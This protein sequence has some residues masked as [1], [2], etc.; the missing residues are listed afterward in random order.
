[1]MNSVTKLP[2][3]KICSGALNIRLPRSLV[4]ADEGLERLCT[5]LSVYFKKGGMQAQLSV[6]DV[7]ELLAAQEKPEDYKDLMVRITGYSA[8]F[9][10]MS[11]SAQDEVIARER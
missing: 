8:V 9:I 10:D 5:L 4:E 7:N 11:R 1:M 2:F 6:T 3:D